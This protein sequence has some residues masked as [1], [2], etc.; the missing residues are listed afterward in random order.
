MFPG[1]RTAR[2]AKMTCG[3]KHR[4]QAMLDGVA[5]KK[6]SQSIC[7]NLDFFCL[8]FQL[9]LN[10]NFKNKQ[11]SLMV[12]SQTIA[13]VSSPKS[14][15]SQKT[16][17]KRASASTDDETAPP[18]LWCSFRMMS[19]DLKAKMRSDI[20]QQIRNCG[21][22]TQRLMH[23]YRFTKSLSAGVWKMSF[24]LAHDR[25]PVRVL[26]CDCTSVFDF[27][28]PSEIPEGDDPH[29]QKCQVWGPEGLQWLK[30]I[31][32]EENRSLEPVQ[33]IKVI[34][35]DPRCIPAEIWAGQMKSLGLFS[36][37]SMLEHAETLGF[38][39]MCN[40]EFESVDKGYFSEPTTI[41][42]QDRSELRET[43]RL[44]VKLLE[45][46]RIKKMES[47]D[48][49]AGEDNELVI[50]AKKKDARMYRAPASDDEFVVGYD[51]NGKPV[52]VRRVSTWH[53]RRGRKKSD[54]LPYPRNVSR[55]ELKMT[56]DDYSLEKVLEAGVNGEELSHEW[57]VCP[58]DE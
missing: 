29:G 8:K 51:R 10:L 47:E 45:E 28:P 24:D 36:K 41:G 7:L 50:A 48:D 16:F 2:N 3:R 4:P 18:K 17:A 54:R 5:R 27:H 13:T 49:L 35:L 58:M 19:Q 26:G 1:P 42:R 43:L 57:L 40:Y 9:N 31:V 22:P 11:R 38:K 12:K 34:V 30:D 20:V 15:K 21:G 53:A 6:P 25:K 37:S 52:S 56:S 46:E 14:S 55:I 44:G 32:V 23:T 33:K 39:P